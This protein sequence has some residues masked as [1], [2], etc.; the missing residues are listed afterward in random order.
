MGLAKAASG[1]HPKPA[2][3]QPGMAEPGRRS[4]PRWTRWLGAALLGVLLAVAAAVISL[5]VFLNGQGLRER[6]E[7]TLTHA[8]R[9]PVSIGRLELSLWTGSA[10]ARDFRMADDP[11]FG[12]EPFVQ[13]NGVR[14]GLE[15]LPLLLHREVSIRSFALERP[16][17]R[18]ERNT[19]GEWNYASLSRPRDASQPSGKA[20]GRMRRLAVS[21]IAVEDGQVLVQVPPDANS[22]APSRD[23]LYRHVSVALKHFDPAQQSAFQVAAVLPGGG[24]VSAAGTAGPWGLQDASATPFSAHIHAKGLDLEAAG[25]SNAKSGVSGLLDTVDLDLAWADRRFHVADLR[26]SGPRLTIDTGRAAEAENAGRK[27]SVW[28]GVLERL[29]IEHARVDL[30]TLTVVRDGGASSTFRQTGVDL[31]SGSAGEVSFFASTTLDGGASARK[32]RRR[33]RAGCAGF[34]KGARSGAQRHAFAWVCD[35]RNG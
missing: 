12:R 8:L 30:G 34:G 11:R 16:S 6:V 2:G 27:P 9:G 31:R 26:V 7:T 28:R 22:G 21:S 33:G 23:R 25:L 3:V 1:T 20:E 15:L 32:I 29:S 18:L 10:V 4:I 17:I 24:T 35:L 19:A 14:L 13:A 5:T